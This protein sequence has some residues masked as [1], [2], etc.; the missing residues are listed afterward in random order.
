MANRTSNTVFRE[1]HMDQ[2][3]VHTDH[4]LDH[5]SYQMDWKD[6][7]IVLALCKTGAIRAAA[8]ELRLSVN[9]LRTRLERLEANCGQI[10][11]RRTRTGVSHTA[12]G[13]KAIEVAKRTKEFGKLV[14]DDQEVLVRPNVISIGCTEGLGTHWLGPRIGELKDR[15]GD[16]AIDLNLSYD[17]NRKNRG[18]FDIVLS[19]SDEP[20]LDRICAR[21][22]TV[23]VRLFAS[24]QYL[25]KNGNPQNWNEVLD[26]TYIEQE[27]QGVHSE[28]SGFILGPKNAEKI[29]SIRTNSSVVH[30]WSIISGLGFGALPTYSALLSRH[31]E[32]INIPIP[33]K[34]DL[35]A[36]Y[37]VSARGSASIK[38]AMDWLK[39]K[40]D[41]VKYP[42]FAEMFVDPALYPTMAEQE[43]VSMLGTPIEGLQRSS[44]NR[45]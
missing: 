44:A 2:S 10:L 30:F 11:F 13:W 39:E 17:Y 12:H 36:S 26:H 35:F 41:P 15:M 32:M 5:K 28:I 23:H 14:V 16:I 40:F 4:G 6:A 1:P 19:Y 29:M 21:I 31:L 18:D 3:S 22:A 38:R 34:F 43:V 9:T 37:Q 27:A 33:I 45:Q 24:R 25:Q 20:D 42:A 8:R 7:E